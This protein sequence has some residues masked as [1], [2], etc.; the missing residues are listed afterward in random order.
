ML[1]PFPAVP[2]DRLT[3]GLFR[4]FNATDSLR[5]A[6]ASASTLECLYVH[7]DW[8]FQYDVRPFDCITEFPRVTQLVEP[9]LACRRRRMACA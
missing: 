7:S 8:N 2:M 3:E 4:G 6:R 5:L 1:Y 9:V